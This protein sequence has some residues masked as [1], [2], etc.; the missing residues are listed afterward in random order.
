[1]GIA[2]SL[3]LGA[4][5]LFYCFGVIDRM[6]CNFI[7]SNLGEIASSPYRTLAALPLRARYG[8]SMREKAR[9]EQVIPIYMYLGVAHT[10]QA[11]QG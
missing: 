2:P 8:V 10:G 6:R 5:L 1:M 3:E 4:L 11:G 7:F 9:I